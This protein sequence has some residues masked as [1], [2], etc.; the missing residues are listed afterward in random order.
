[1]D[2]DENGESW[3]GDPSQPTVLEAGLVGGLLLALDLKVLT[4]IEFMAGL[5]FWF[6]LTRPNTVVSFNSSRFKIF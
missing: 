4:Q 6:F 5:D 3:V 2:R 1:M